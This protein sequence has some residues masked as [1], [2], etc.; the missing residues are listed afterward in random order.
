M[1]RLEEVRFVVADIGEPPRWI[2][3]NETFDFW[4]EEIR[5]HLAEPETSVFL[6]DFPNQYCYLA[7]KWKAYTGETIILFSKAH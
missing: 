4:R 6:E 2:P 5:P 3:N 1:L 7:S